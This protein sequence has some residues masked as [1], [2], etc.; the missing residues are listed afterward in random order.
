MTKNS[1]KGELPQPPI[2]FFRPPHRFAG[3]IHSDP[4]EQIAHFSV[5]GLRAPFAVDS[6]SN[7]IVFKKDQNTAS[8]LSLVTNEVTQL[9]L[10]DRSFQIFSISSFPEI[11]LVVCLNN[12][13]LLYVAKASVEE[14]Q[15]VLHSPK[16]S[17]TKCAVFPE[18]G[19]TLGFFSMVVTPDKSLLQVLVLKNTFTKQ[20]PSQYVIEVKESPTI[21]KVQFRKE[22]FG[23]SHHIFQISCDNKFIRKSLAG[24]GKIL[25]TQ[26]YDLKA[27]KHPPEFEKLTIV[28]IDDET[29]VGVFSSNDSEEAQGQ[30]EL[31]QLEW[32]TCTWHRFPLEVH[33]SHWP[34]ANASLRIQ[35]SDVFL[36][37]DCGVK[38]CATRSHLFKLRLKQPKTLAY[39]SAIPEERFSELLNQASCSS[40]SNEALEDSDFDD[41]LECAVCQSLFENPKQLVCG[42]SFCEKCCKKMASES[43]IVCPLCR[44]ETTLERTLPTNYILKQVVGKFKRQ[45]MRMSRL[46][47]CS[48]CP[49]SLHNERLFGCKTCHEE[50][51]IENALC[52]RCGLTQHPGHHVVSLEILS[53]LDKE[54]LTYSLSSLVNNCPNN[55]DLVAS[56]DESLKNMKEKLDKTSQKSMEHAEK[57]QKTVETTTKLP[58]V[59]KGYSATVL[60]EVAESGKLLKEINTVLQMQANTL[61]KCEELF[62]KFV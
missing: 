16:F 21:D 14:N 48:M 52:A 1:S 57:F 36:V 46:V 58:F 49:E 26:T 24:I 23:F 40:S 33:H 30:A 2:E 38:D 54:N 43:G 4:M 50:N 13:G 32:G 55:S 31:W 34:V 28:Q 62:D 59:T 22:F 12:S 25:T 42:H 56:I 47:P 18:N 37:G 6:A 20:I 51:L 19:D 8:H 27:N 7:G 15:L 10:S 41:V 11:G 53:H 17:G 60:E 5:G 61:K 35:A 44:S 29:L 9:Q 39:L 3:A 45:R